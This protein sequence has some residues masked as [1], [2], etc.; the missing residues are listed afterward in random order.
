MFALDPIIAYLR[1]QDP[2]LNGARSR[3]PNDVR[4]RRNSPEAQYHRT[5]EA[6]TRSSSS[7]TTPRNP[8]TLSSTGSPKVFSNELPDRPRPGAGNSPSTSLTVHGLLAQ[9]GSSMNACR[10]FWADD[11]QVF[12]NLVREELPKI[13]GQSSESNLRSGGEKCIVLQWDLL[14]R[15]EEGG[16]AGSRSRS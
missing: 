13:T 12:P 4:A 10:P 7:S 8:G 14:W 2:R 1:P 11:G 15:K 9:T 6:T 3:R 5:S 16:S